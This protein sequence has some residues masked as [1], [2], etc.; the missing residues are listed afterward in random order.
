MIGHVYTV[1]PALARSFH[2]FPVVKRAPIAKRKGAAWSW[3]VLVDRGEEY[4][5]HDRY[6]TA[7]AWEGEDS[8]N[9]GHYFDSLADAERD[10]YARM[11]DGY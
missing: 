2:G 8:W 3:I 10:F 9:H 1:G 7:Q 6:V 5:E 4:A 11:H